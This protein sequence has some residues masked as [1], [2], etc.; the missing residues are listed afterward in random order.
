MWV[1]TGNEVVNEKLTRN[2]GECIYCGATDDLQQEHIV[3]YS[4]GG[5]WSLLGASCPK[6]AAITSKFELDVSR[7][8][9]IV[10]RT[11]LG[12]PTRRKNMRPSSFSM[13]VELDSGRRHVLE[14]PV[15]DCPVLLQMPLYRRPRYLASYPYN[16][17]VVVTGF[18]GYATGFGT[19]QKKYGVQS[20]YSTTTF[21]TS[22]A[23]LLAKIAYGFAVLQYGLQEI[24]EAYVLPSII[25]EKDDVGYWVGCSND[26]K[27]P[28][29]PPR[30]RYLHTIDVDLSQTTEYKE[31]VVRLRLFAMYPTPEYL[32]VVGR[33]N[34][35][36][37][38]D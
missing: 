13:M 28:R 33:L 12:L 31:V 14:V 27:P 4:L 34:K 23:R 16:K 29:V 10:P 5:P 21:T 20:L 6:C 9:L 37:C 18:L 24:T 36:G 19:L 11:T 8:T 26:S 30:E 32:V 7:N 17:G 35:P 38:Q 1:W 3:P 2:I 25:G 22:F 15:S